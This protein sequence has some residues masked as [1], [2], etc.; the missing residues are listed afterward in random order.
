MTFMKIQ[1]PYVKKIINQR[2]IWVLLVILAFDAAL[3]LLYTF[4]PGKRL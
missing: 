3:V 4:V 2:A 1:E